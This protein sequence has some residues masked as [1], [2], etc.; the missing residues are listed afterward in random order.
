MLDKQNTKAFLFNRKLIQ[1]AEVH[2]SKPPTFP[3]P[4]ALPYSKH[5]LW[6]TEGSSLLVVTFS[7]D[8]THP[9]LCASVS[10]SVP[11]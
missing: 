2:G 5:K 4:N 10:P 3:A 7:Q 6:G 11:R 9:M 8:A 1:N